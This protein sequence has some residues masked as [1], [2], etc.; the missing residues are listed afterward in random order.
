MWYYTN[1]MHNTLFNHPKR[2]FVLQAVFAACMVVLLMLVNARFTNKDFVLTGR[3]MSGDSHSVGP[4]KEVKR[5]VR[6]A[7]KK[8]IKKRV[9][10]R[11]L[12]AL[13]SGASQSSK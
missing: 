11:R 1:N 6:K 8:P 5:T 13:H 3:T 12:R 9:T 4:A 10:V 7:V 2:L